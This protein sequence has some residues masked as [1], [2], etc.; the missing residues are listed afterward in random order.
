MTDIK[1]IVRRAKQTEWDEARKV[2]ELYLKD[3]PERMG[4][5]AGLAYW[6]GKVGDATMYVY[7][8]KTAVV[9]VGC[10]E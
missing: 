2:A 9:V 10:E 6:N 8:T 3:Y 4:I 1:L 7:R 5:R